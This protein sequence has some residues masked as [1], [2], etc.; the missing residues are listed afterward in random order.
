MQLIIQK[1]P[2]CIWHI[3]CPKNEHNSGV[4][5]DYPAQGDTTPVECLHCGEKGS[6]LRGT[7]FDIPFLAEPPKD[8]TQEGE[9]DE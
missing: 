9:G 3:D 4:V 5:K 1:F 7:H 2:R 6:I 8:N